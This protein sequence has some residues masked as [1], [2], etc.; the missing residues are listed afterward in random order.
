MKGFLLATLLAGAHGIGDVN[1]SLTQFGLGAQGQLIFF[2]SPPSRHPHGHQTVAHQCGYR[3]HDCPHCGP[4]C[5]HSNRPPSTPLTAP[6]RLWRCIL[7]T[8]TQQSWTLHPAMDHSMSMPSFMRL[9]LLQLEPQY[10][11]LA[12]SQP[13]PLILQESLPSASTLRYATFL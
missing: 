9:V 11:R 4:R 12:L 10:Y 8:T 6:A 1:P 5:T 7:S 3:I 13:H 2:G